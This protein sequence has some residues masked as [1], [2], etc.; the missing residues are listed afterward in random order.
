[1]MNTRSE[2]G[3]S[4]PPQDLTDILM[5]MAAGLALQ[6]TSAQGSTREGFVAEAYFRVLGLEKLRP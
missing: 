4:S 1:M 5:G 6:R 3:R 2:F